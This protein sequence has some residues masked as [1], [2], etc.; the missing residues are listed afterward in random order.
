MDEK[1]D[2]KMAKMF[3]EQIVLHQEKLEH[4]KLRMR[5]IFA[6]QKEKRLNYGHYLI[7]DHAIS[8]E[9]GYLLWLQEHMHIKK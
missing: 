9:K 2:E 8:H 5:I 7:L 4:L 6:T 3:E 1:E